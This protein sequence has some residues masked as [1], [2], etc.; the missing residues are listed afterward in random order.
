MTQAL[1]KAKQGVNS[2]LKRLIG[3]TK[4]KP[5]HLRHEPS[6]VEQQHPLAPRPGGDDSDIVRASDTRDR[7]GHHPAARL[8]TLSMEQASTLKSNRASHDEDDSR[9][10]ITTSHALDQIR[11]KENN[12]QAE[13]GIY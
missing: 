3:R 13:L 7:A 5:L 6:F 1:Q 9:Q 11:R 4:K 12:Q 8:A 2:M 10:P